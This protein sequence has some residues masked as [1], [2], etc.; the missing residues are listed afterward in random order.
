MPEM[1]LT[2]ARLYTTETVW[3]WGKVFECL[4]GGGDDSQ[5]PVFF[6][7]LGQTLVSIWEKGIKM[8]EYWLLNTSQ[9]WGTSKNQMGVLRMGTTKAAHCE[10]GLRGDVG[11]PRGRPREYIQGSECQRH[12]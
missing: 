6:L 2:L 4:G 11:I 5:I 8:E 9:K 3:T 10:A 7:V 1:H 12:V